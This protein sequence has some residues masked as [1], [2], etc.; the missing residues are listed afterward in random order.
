M[1]FATLDGDQALY[2]QFFN[3]CDSNQDGDI[4]NADNM[5]IVTHNQ[6]NVNSKASAKF[7]GSL[8]NPHVSPQG[9]SF[10]LSPQGY[11][12]INGNLQNTLRPA[13]WIVVSV[14]GKTVFAMYNPD[15]H[16]D[17]AELGDGV[18]QLPASANMK[19]G[20]NVQLVPNNGT[21]PSQPSGGIIALTGWGMTTPKL[22]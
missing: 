11:S 1:G 18:E 10:D 4:N 5:N 21:L 17:L 3:K 22:A 13:D 20:D 9:V 7:V 14:G 2:G 12:T 8:V 19:A 6:G 15:K 16:N